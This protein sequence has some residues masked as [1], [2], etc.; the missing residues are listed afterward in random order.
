M[1]DGTSNRG[2]VGAPQRYLTPSAKERE[3]VFWEEKKRDFASR[4]RSTCLGGMGYPDPEIYGAC[5]RLN[6]LPGVCTL[7]SCAGHGH[8]GQIWLWL[9]VPTSAAFDR[10]APA[11]AASP[12]IERL[13]KLWLPEGQEIVDVEFKSGHHFTEAT[14][15]IVAFFAALGGAPTEPSEPYWRQVIEC[16]RCAMTCAK[17]QWLVDTGR[18]TG[19]PCPCN[20]CSLWRSAYARAAVPSVA[21][22]REDVLRAEGAE[23]AARVCESRAASH[24]VIHAQDEAQKCALAIRMLWRTRRVPGTGAAREPTC[25][26]CGGS[27]RKGCDVGTYRS[28]PCHCPAG[29]A[30][31]PDCPHSLDGKHSL[32]NE[33]RD[34]RPSDVP[35]CVHC[36][37]AVHA[38]LPGREAAP[39]DMRWKA[40]MPL[41]G[42]APTPEGERLGEGPSE[43]PHNPLQKGWP[44]TVYTTAHGLRIRHGWSGT[45]LDLYEAA[46]KLNDYDSAWRAALREYGSPPEGTC[47]GFESAD[48]DEG[49]PTICRHCGGS[50]HEH[51]RLRGE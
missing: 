18:A 45:E 26:D 11:L 31:E 1:A 41:M 12:L 2:P 3:L 36:G 7:Q 49:D 21:E 30:R 46:R 38:A 29:A 25:P 44:W 22:P 40:D 32:T 14:D 33:D 24:E 37:R 23:A 28:L 48:G 13:R 47:H 51:Q 20:N 16:G 35:L 9:D 5:D 17:T 8:A 10:E 43:P 6:A 34:G 27:G 4:H 42:A 15:S 50:I 39:P 19:G